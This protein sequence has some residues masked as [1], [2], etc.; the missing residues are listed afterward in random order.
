MIQKEIQN[1]D[2]IS[3][4]RKLSN[5]EFSSDYILLNSSKN[6]IFNNGTKS[7]IGFKLDKY[8]YDE[9]DLESHLNNKISEY[10]FGFFSYEH[11]LNINCHLN[12]HISFPKLLFASYRIIL[13][14]DHIKQ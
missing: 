7:L 6:D 4:G 5:S 2:P 3:F 9:I 11:G 1:I 12:H 14:I 10:L 13:V 8:I